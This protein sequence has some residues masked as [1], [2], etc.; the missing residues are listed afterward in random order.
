MAQRTAPRGSAHPTAEGQPLG[1]A[2]IGRRSAVFH[3]LSATDIAAAHRPAPP[4]RPSHASLRCAPAEQRA[5]TAGRAAPLT[6]RPR[7][8]RGAAR[9][10][11]RGGAAARSACPGGG[12]SPSVPSRLPDE[13]ADGE[14]GTVG[15]SGDFNY[16]FFFFP[17]LL[18]FSV[19]PGPSTALGHPA[20]PRPPTCAAP[21]R[22]SAS[23]PSC[24][25]PAAPTVRRAAPGERPGGAPRRAQVPRT[26]LPTGGST[27]FTTFFPNCFVVLLFFFPVCFWSRALTCRERLL[28]VSE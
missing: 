14:G 17:P 26:R 27:P 11:L 3:R 5:A 15:G 6:R 10:M 13:P 8:R 18:P 7:T 4:S 22:L 23:R 9:A 12:P 2:A 21:S 28:H 20:R 19:M 24:R 25:A 1:E 16:F